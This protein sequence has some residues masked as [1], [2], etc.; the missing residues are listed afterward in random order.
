MS[1][2]N[3]LSLRF[4]LLTEDAIAIV[5]PEGEL[6]G[7]RSH[8]LLRVRSLEESELSAVLI[9]PLAKCVVSIDGWV[10]QRDSIVLR[11]GDTSSDSSVSHSLH[12]SLWATG[13]F[14]KLFTHLDPATIL[15]THNKDVSVVKEEISLIN[16]DVN[17]E[18]V[19]DSLSALLCL[20]FF[21]NDI[22]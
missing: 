16:R 19:S 18:Q 7:L 12:Q 22:N 13:C 17:L 5:R 8:W 6:H 2:G 3:L 4:N 1:T 10:A 20:E 9:A 14:C 21:L 15:N 11:V